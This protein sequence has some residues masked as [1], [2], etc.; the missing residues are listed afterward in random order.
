MIEVCHN[1]TLPLMTHYLGGFSYPNCLCLVLCV[2]YQCSFLY[3]FNFLCYICWACCTFSQ[4]RGVHALLSGADWLEL[5]QT[6]VLHQWEQCARAEP[7][8]SFWL[9]VD[10]WGSSYKTCSAFFVYSRLKWKL[11]L[12]DTR[13]RFSA[14]QIATRLDTSQQFFIL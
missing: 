6:T 3:A 12:P 1:E 13:I 4:P 5:T 14:A 10:S 7:C 2:Y 11:L 8:C 9:L